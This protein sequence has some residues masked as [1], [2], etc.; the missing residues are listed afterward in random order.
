[1]GDDT[2][3]DLDLYYKLDTFLF[4]VF[5]EFGFII[6]IHSREKFLFIGIHS[7][8]IIISL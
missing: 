8:K 7:I 6:K 5:L 4:G 2:L 1:M 3:K